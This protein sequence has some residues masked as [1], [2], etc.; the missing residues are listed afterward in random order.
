MSKDNPT[1]SELFPEG[2][3]VYYEGNKPVAFVKEMKAK[4]NF[5]PSKDNPHWNRYSGYA[6]DLPGPLMDL[7]YGNCDYP[8]GS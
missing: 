2:R 5:D 6:F 1:W 4:F 7:V 3:R 8:I